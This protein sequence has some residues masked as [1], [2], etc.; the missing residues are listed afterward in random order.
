MAEAGG[1]GDPWADA[2][3]PL[4]TTVA[5][6]QAATL[7]SWNQSPDIPFDRAA[8]P[9]R[10]CEHGCV[11]CYAR[12]THA[13]LGYSPGLDFETRLVAKANAVQALRTELARP[14]YQP[15]PIN[16]GSA[17]D[18][19]QPIERQWQLTRG[20]LAL[21][22]ETRH[23]ATIVTKSAL[24]ERDIDLLSEL[25]RQQLITVYVS[26]TTLDATVAR[27]M[28][29]RASAPWR[30]LEAV[31]AL[32]RAGVPVGV[33]VAP[34]IPFINDDQVEHILDAAQQAGASHASY[35]VLR[36]PWE[37]REIFTQWLHAH[38]PDRAARVLHRIQDLRQGKQNDSTFGRRM[39]GQGIWAD[40]LAQRFRLALRRSGLL[41]RRKLALDTGLFV[42][43]SLNG[44]QSLF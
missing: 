26:I 34:V 15:A 7:L 33:L 8:N 22:C 5:T 6:E 44:Q 12:P 1:A 39:R 10:G 20:L 4:R 36:L 40:L 14:G 18:A 9:Y 16:I 21:M 41:P 19:Y 11:Y 38:F 32:S 42:P 3:A 43:P 23:P 2:P 37:L 13:Y 28:E 35:T 17:T 24:I 25:A 30:R 29:P 27:L 31:K